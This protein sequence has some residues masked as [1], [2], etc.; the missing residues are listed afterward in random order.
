MKKITAL[1]M[2]IMMVTVVFA[3]CSSSGEKYVDG[4]YRAEDAEFSHGYKEFVEITVASGKIN[5]VVMDA[6]GEDGT[7]L[8]STD[9]EYKAG[10]EGTGNDTYP[11][12]FYPSLASQLE[13][14]QN[15]D[16]VEAVAG[17]TGSSESFKRLAAAA[18]ENAKSG[19]TETAV[20]AAPAE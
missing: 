15:L 2:A 3:G 18:L 14:T 5:K 16:K 10:Y 11:E 17:A 12:V 8:K 6:I 19:N 13:K 9:Q 4:T 7:T 1:L 20:V